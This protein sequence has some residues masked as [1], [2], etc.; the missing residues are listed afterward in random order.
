MRVLA[1][2]SST[3]WLS[4]ALNDGQRWYERRER[5]GHGHSERVLPLVDEVLGE[6]QTTLASVDGI[7]FGAGPGGFTGV[8]IACGVAQGLAL[9]AELPLVPV[10]TLTALAHV[11]WRSRGWTRVVACL[12]ARMH[13]VYVAAVVRQRDAWIEVCAPAVRQPDDVIRPDGAWWGVGEGLLRYPGLGA[14]LRMEASDPLLAPTA[15]AVGELAIPI[16]EGGGGVA[17]DDALPLYVRHRVA[18][19]T[20]ERAAGERL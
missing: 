7:A 20:R 5:A 1:I 9:G 12:D 19:T 8:R 13:E 11:A 10:S 2:E 16:L 6:A 3:E 15:R 4:V 18:L 14:R 17:P